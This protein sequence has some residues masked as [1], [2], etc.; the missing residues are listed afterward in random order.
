M[1]AKRA[2]TVL[3]SSLVMALGISIASAA[4]PTDN[5]VVTPGNTQGWAATDTRSGGAVN[6]VADSEA[7]AGFGALQLTTNATTDSKAQFM[8]AA[9]VPLSEV[10]E[11]SYFTK[12]IGASFAQGDVSY[13][14]PIFAN[15]T[16]GFTTL[17]YE[18][19]QNGD[20]TTGDWQQW[21]VL[22]GKFWSSRTVTCGAGGLTAG[23]GGAPF[24]SL[25]DIAEMCPG[26]KV[27]GFGVNIG[28]N[29]PS[30]NVETDLVS[31]N[32]TAYDFELVSKNECKNNGYKKL[33]DANGKPF[34]NM[35]DCISYTATLGQNQAAGTT[36]E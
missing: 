23:G 3:T 12:Q 24:Y 2:L 34:K 30:Y 32:G 21:N 13:Q 35:G 20:V 5:V 19:Y 22:E 7:P 25:A 10:T 4:P 18:P 26:A 36:E 17:V 1:V 8:H 28:S 6:F 29:N 27:L 16:T 14:I 31:F 11:L 33:G 9:N 15:G